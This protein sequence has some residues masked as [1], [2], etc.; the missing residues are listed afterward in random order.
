MLQFLFLTNSLAPKLRKIYMV[1]QRSRM[2]VTLGVICFRGLENALTTKIAEILAH[3]KLEPTLK[4]DFRGTLVFIKK[5]YI[6][7]F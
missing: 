5:N 7:H 4:F 6:S 2:G 1:N 3:F